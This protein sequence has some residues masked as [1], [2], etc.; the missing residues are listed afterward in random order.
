MR[1][2][3]TDLVS[4]H[5]TPSASDIQAGLA[6]EQELARLQ[7]LQAQ[8]GE[9]I[10]NLY[11]R[12]IQLVAVSAELKTLANEAPSK[13]DKDRVKEWTKALRALLDTFEFKSVPTGDID[14]DPAMRPVV[15]GYDIGF[16]GSA[17]DGIR[18]RWSYLLSLAATASAN[19]G[20]HPGLLILDEPAQ[21]GV[22]TES[23]VSLL[24]TMANAAA[25]TQMFVTT[26]EPPELLREWLGDADYQLIDLG[27]ER[28]LQPLTVDEPGS[29]EPEEPDLAGTDETDKS[30]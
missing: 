4:A 3:K 23:I 17:S 27:D 11:E 7:N 18:L 1:A 2:L 15:D 22:E 25:G 21:Q 8:S 14:L 28:V 30:E 19:D 13:A 9:D 12:T 10:D 6:Q 24:E 5:G 26:S 16:Q 20:A 29:L